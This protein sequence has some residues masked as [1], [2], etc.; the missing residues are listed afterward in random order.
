MAATTVVYL[1]DRNKAEN[2]QG[3]AQYLFILP[4]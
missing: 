1:V 2:V 4:L 3:N